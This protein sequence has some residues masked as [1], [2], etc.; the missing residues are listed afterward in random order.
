MRTPQK[1]DWRP[2]LE[3]L[4]QCSQD[5]GQKLSEH[6]L[7]NS[8]TIDEAMNITM[9]DQATNKPMK[10]IHYTLC[11]SGIIFLAGCVTQSPPPPPPTKT[12][13]CKIPQITPLPETKEYQEKGGLGISIAPAAYQAVRKEIKTRQRVDPT[14]AESILMSDQDL[15][16]SAF[17]VETTATVLET[18]PK[19]LAYLVKINNKLD[20]VFR[21]AGTVVQFNAG[22]KLVAVDQRG[23]VELSSAI[24]PPRSELQVTVYGPPLDQMADKAT[25]GLFLYDVVTAVGTAGNVTEKQNYEWFFDYSTKVVEDT[26]QTTSQRIRVIGQ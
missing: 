3:H 25:I 24:V 7:D 1:I 20:R 21:G 17:F 5:A 13:S 14:L 15:R 11:C 4:P 22:G 10:W 19:Q 18:N 2:F 16:S 9:K 26:A 23:Y 8:S 6:P 12:I